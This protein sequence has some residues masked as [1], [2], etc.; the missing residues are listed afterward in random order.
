MSNDPLGVV[1]EGFDN[2][3]N[4]MGQYKDGLN[5]YQYADSTP[6][7][8]SDIYGFDTSNPGDTNKKDKV[9]C[10]VKKT[11][12]TYS[13]AYGATV[14]YIYKNE[15][16]ECFQKTIE[17]PNGFSPSGA[18]YC[19]YK[20]IGGEAIYKVYDSHEGECCW[21]TM[22][23][24]VV[25]HHRIKVACDDETFVVHVYPDVTGGWDDT[26]ITVENPENDLYDPSYV[27][28]ATK[29]ISCDV[30]KSLRSLEGNPWYFS[31]IRIPYVP[32]DG[33]C[34][35]FATPLFFEIGNLCP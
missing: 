21:C 6:V 16:T 26:E 18:C 35:Q 15:K 17:N 1:S 23:L 13:Y 7:V 28:V 33:N 30:A 20:N 24:E 11:T 10:K 22:T 5:V 25:G 12:T 34:A 2:R 8:L 29:R 3:F 14:P 9:C 4:P 31:P 19:H 32:G 27:I